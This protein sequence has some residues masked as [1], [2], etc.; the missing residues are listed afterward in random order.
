[1][2][3]TTGARKSARK[4]P[5]NADPWFDALDRARRA[6]A[7]GIDEAWVGLEPTF[8]SAKAVHKWRK[9]SGRPGGEDAYFED[10]WMLKKANAVGRR[11]VELYRKLAAEG[12]PA[13]VFAR[14]EREVDRDPWDVERQNLRFSNA[15]RGPDFELRFGL[16]PETFEFSIKPV[17]LAWLY[18]E[19]FVAFLQR[20]VFDVPRKEK[21]VASMAHGGG[22]F[23]FSAKAFLGGSLLADDIATRVNHPELSTW[24]LDY[25][26]SD[27]RSFRAT[28]RRLDAFRTTID[29]YWHGA[30][31]PQSIGT[32]TVEN[33]L[34]DRGFGPSHVPAKGAMDARGPIGSPR[35]VFQTNFAFARSVRLHAQ[36]IDPGYWQSSH[37][38]EDGYRPDQI[39]RYSEG[40]L[41]RVQI[42]GELHVKS[43]KV[44]DPK[45]VPELDAPLEAA[46]LYDEASWE[47]RGQMSK[48]SAADLVEAVLLDA[49]YARWLAAHPRVRL[50]GV[51]AQD[52]L[53]ADAPETLA[54]RAPARLAQLRKAARAENL[55]A[56]HGRVKSDRVEPEVLF[57]SAWHAL[58]D[59]DRAEIAREALA[60]FVE[61]VQRASETD[62][63]G[64]H[65]D[66]MDAHRH[67]V[68][69][70]L[71]S[72]LAADR[73][74]LT[75]EL[76]RE[77]GAFEKE[78]DRWLAR[79]PM[80]SPL[81]ERPPWEDARS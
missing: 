3:R 13:C 52:Q 64:S 62:P 18:D 14:V 22:Q 34:L 53:L 51:L 17:P 60:G 5:A 73:E 35:D 76:A 75:G 31:H 56:S 58:E 54:Q 45:D 29:Q 77:L 47:M 20:F 8:S 65:G 26:N 49:H 42:A 6:D 61:R 41:N 69:P 28:G 68:H 9:M 30:Y 46:M 37:P 24:I 21:L 74:A 78:P 79:R 59:G 50:R 80:W 66:P 10:R 19:R 39:M 48:T 43:G 63:R 25:P 27:D 40:N 23:S 2:K 44:L 33:A 11:I 16:D 38:D 7:T 57:W 15:R 70:L 4:T 1:M 67:R 72:A 71:W 55:A 36:S 32:L 12:D 81:D